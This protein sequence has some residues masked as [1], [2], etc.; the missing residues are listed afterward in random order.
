MAQLLEKYVPV[1]YL[2]SGEK[3]FP[4]S[5]DFVI[6]QSTLVENGVPT[7]TNLTSRKL[8]DI[9]TTKYKGNYGLD[10]KI[11]HVD[12]P[13]SL[14]PGQKDLSAPVYGNVREFQ[15]TIE[16]YY[17]LYFPYNGPR[18][19]LGLQDAGE[20]NSDIEHVTIEISKSTMEPVRMYFGAH[21]STD[22]KW[23]PW[24]EVQKTR[25]THPLV[26]LALDGHGAYPKAGY[27]RRIFG[28]AND[29][30]D[31]G[32]KWE[33]RVIQ[34][35]R[36]NEPDF[37]PDRDGWLHFAGRWGFD[38]I[39]GPS[40]KD[41]WRLGE[42]KTGLTTPPFYSS[43]MQQTSTF[44]TTALGFVMVL[45]I[46]W[47]GLWQKRV[48]RRTYFAMLIVIFAVLANVTKRAILKFAA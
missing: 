5:I 30:L 27:A 29:E 14:W 7:Q 25:N 22:G 16:L 1:F 12:F 19:I 24:S 42:V 13:K 3:Y 34:V 37:D 40:A 32:T 4:S 35:F 38:G 44:L 2:H 28:L 36:K 18:K 11:L 26:L 33:P 39:S 23:V 46:I 20:H 48:S 43:V 8:Y 10:Y 21:T 45:A 9:S 47:L 31:Y 17:I 6:N 15:D 41:F